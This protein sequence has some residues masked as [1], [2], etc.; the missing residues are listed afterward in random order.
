MGILL[1]RFIIPAFADQ[2]PNKQY[3]KSEVGLYE[4]TSHQ[5][6]LKNKFQPTTLK[7]ILN[8]MST[9]SLVLQ[10]NYHRVDQSL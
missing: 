4:D 7:E 6:I 3:C 1:D 9:L 10:N 2:N 8:Y 5:S